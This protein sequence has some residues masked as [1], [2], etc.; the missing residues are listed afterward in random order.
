MKLWERYSKLAVTDIFTLGKNAKIRVTNDDGSTRTFTKSTDTYS[1]TDNTTGTF[2]PFTL[3]QTATGAGASVDGVYFKMA[4]E[5]ALG[6]YA[7]ALNA[8]LD[9]GT[10]GRV[11]GLGAPFC[12]ELD[13]GPGTTQ[14]SYAVFE[15]ELNCPTSGSTGTRTSFMTLNLWGAGSGAVDDNGFL[16][17]LN[18]VAGSDAGHLYDEVTEQAVNAQ[19]RLRVKVNSTVWYI[20]L[21]DTAALS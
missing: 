11:T 8:K 15:A 3:S 14:G 12:A 7:N 9:F 6:T 2:S 10:A 4:T 21:C 20:P 16:F 5:V 13:L 19:A 1:V 18:G 17:D